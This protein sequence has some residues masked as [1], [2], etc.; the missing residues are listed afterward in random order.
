MKILLILIAG[1]SM[2]GLVAFMTEVAP[3]IVP[4]LLA[5]IIA[6]IVIDSFAETQST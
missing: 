2:G 5:I 1:L 6:A 3:M 4:A